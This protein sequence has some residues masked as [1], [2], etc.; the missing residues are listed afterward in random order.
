MKCIHTGLLL[1]LCAMLAGCTKSIRPISN[2][3]YA[4]DA[5]PNYSYYPALAGG[6]E[7]FQYHGELSEF[8]VLGIARGEITSEAEIRRA[9]DNAKQVRLHPDSSILLIQSGAVFP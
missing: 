1:S 6:N 8:D 7:P 2:S 4:P 9:L 3:S 5:A